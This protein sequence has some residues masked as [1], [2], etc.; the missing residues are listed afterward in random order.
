MRTYF[1]SR[2]DSACF[3]FLKWLAPLD[4][5]FSPLLP[6]MQLVQRPLPEESGKWLV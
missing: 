5:V 6:T 4:L 1:F 2:N 3:M